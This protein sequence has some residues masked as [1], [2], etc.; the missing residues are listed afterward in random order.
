MA[1]ATAHLFPLLLVLA[2]ATLHQAVAAHAMHESFKDD[3]RP[4]IFLGKFRFSRN[5]SVSIAATAGGEADMTGPFLA[6]FFLL[7]DGMRLDQVIKKTRTPTYRRCI[8]SSPYVV[9]LVTFAAL[10][11]GGGGRYKV[12]TFP[13][14]RTGEYSVYFANCVPGTRVTMDV[15]VELSDSNPDGGEDPV[16]MVYAFFAVSYGV[17]LIAWLHRTLVRSCSMARPVHDV[18][19]GL[20]AVLMLHCLTAAYDGRYASI[21]GTSHGWNVPVPCVALRLVKNAMLFPAVALIGAGW[22]LPEPFVPQREL[23]VLTAMVPLQVYMAI[24]TTLSGDAPAFTAGGVAWT[25]SHV[26]VLVQLACCVAVLMPMGRA[27]QALRK[28]ADTDDK[29]ERRLTKLALFRQLYLAVAVYL[30]YTRM[31]VFI[32]KL[33]VGA[34]SGYRWASVTVEEAASVAFYLFM[35]CRFSPAEDIQLEDAEELIPGGV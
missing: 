28:E 26:F 9:R 2:G 16:A 12:G 31:A 1:A 35:F 18:M 33:L 8:L 34:G 23:N 10:D 29:A 22:S 25:W 19:S 14:T 27:I 30:Y 32:L 17:F 3:P 21:V 15:R 11:G 4:L 13:I 5:G 20:L 6:G 24:A 7:P